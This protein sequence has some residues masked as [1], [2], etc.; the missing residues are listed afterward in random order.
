[1]QYFRPIVTGRRVLARGLQHTL[2]R[3]LFWSPSFG[4]PHI[5]YQSVSDDKCWS[6]ITDETYYWGCGPPKFAEVE[7]VRAFFERR[8]DPYKTTLAWKSTLARAEANENKFHTM[9]ILLGEAIMRFPSGHERVLDLIE[10]MCEIAAVADRRDRRT[11]FLA[12]T[13]LYLRDVLY[14]RYSKGCMHQ[15]V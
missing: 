11:R 2:P 8:A 15:L 6:E 5:D 14:S 9:C 3:R 12:Y 1:M 4:F 13:T 10:A 7:Y